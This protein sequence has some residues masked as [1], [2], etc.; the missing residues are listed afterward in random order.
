[1]NTLVDYYTYVNARNTLRGN[2]MAEVNMYS[3][4]VCIYI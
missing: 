3:V 1:M 2:N 4:C